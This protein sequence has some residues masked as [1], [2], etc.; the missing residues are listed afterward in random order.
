MADIINQELTQDVTQTAEVLGKISH[1]RLRIAFLRMP[2]SVPI[3][4][5]MFTG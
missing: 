1:F 2:C 5:G 4:F 3:V